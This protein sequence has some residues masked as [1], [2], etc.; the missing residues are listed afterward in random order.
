MD[1]LWL[2]AGGVFFGVSGMLIRF[3]A[4]LQTEE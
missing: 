2:T 1:I 3:L 4:H